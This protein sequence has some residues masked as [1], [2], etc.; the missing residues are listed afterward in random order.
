MDIN[1]TND[2]IKKITV[3]K[4]NNIRLKRY[5]YEKTGKGKTYFAMILDRII[6][7][8][9]F[10][11]SLIIF[12]FFISKSFLFTLLISI[13]IFTLYNFVVYRINKSKLK[14]KIQIV[15]R[16][17]VLKKTFKELL[18]HSPND[19]TEH[20][21]D[22]LDKYGL[23]NIMKLERRGI[24]MVGNLSGTKIGI[25]CFQYDNDYKVGVDIIRDFFI[26]LRREDIKKGVIITTSS[27]T[28]EA[29]VLSEKLKKHVHIQLIDIE[30]LIEIIRKANLYPSDVEIKKLIFDE[31]SDN[32]IHFKSYKDIVLSKSKI[33]KYIFLGTSMIVFGNFTPYKGYYMIVGYIIFTIALISIIKLISDLFKLNEEKHEEK[34][35]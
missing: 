8:V 27:F 23:E 14:R 13:Q 19:Y 15:N 1:V 6:F 16:Q 31:I 7:K 3:K 33:I 24:D 30:E 29:R 10:L 25:K 35:L 17:V 26:G 18:N 34:I 12:F 4:I 28:Q 32:K 2:K 9:F 21:M 11:S 5:Y 22:I 20:I